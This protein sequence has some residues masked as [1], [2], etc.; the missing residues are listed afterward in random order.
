[1]HPQAE[2]FRTFL[3]GGVDL[4][5]Y[6]LVLDRLLRATTKKGRQFF[7][8]KVHP[9]TKSWLCLCIYLLLKCQEFLVNVGVSCVLLLWT[10]GKRSA[11]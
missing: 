3:L 5:V 1:V 11:Q 4:G 6:L 9:Q 10:T 8:E 7:E 2:Q